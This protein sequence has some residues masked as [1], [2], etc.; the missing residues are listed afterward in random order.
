MLEA[1]KAAFASSSLSDCQPMGL[2]LADWATIV[3][4]FISI[5]A[6]L[7]YV[8]TPILRHLGIF[9]PPRLRTWW[10]L[11]RSVAPL[12]RENQR[13]FETFGPRSSRSSVSPAGFD[14]ATWH[15]AR[16]RIADNNREILILINDNRNLI[17]SRFRE[18]FDK[19]ADHIIAFSAHVHDEN[20]D[21]RNHQFPS[22]IDEIFK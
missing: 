12:F 1:C 7:R 2:G 8:V 17:P 4:L 22:E 9:G 5:V 6:A 18:I 19:W 10:G 11:R 14:L 21:Y 13:I 20:V 3:A 16:L 15:N